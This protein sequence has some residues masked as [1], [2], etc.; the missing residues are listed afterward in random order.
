MTKEIVAEEKVEEVK[1]YDSVNALWCA[2][3][4]RGMSGLVLAEGL[5]QGDDCPICRQKLA[6]HE[7]SQEQ[8]GVLKTA[9]QARKDQEEL[10]EIRRRERDL[11]SI[12][13]IKDPGEMIGEEK[14]AREKELLALKGEIDELKSLLKAQAKNTKSTN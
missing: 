4:Q 1:K 11:R 3:C 8:V 2:K 7:I 5:K 9:A 13:H 14:R 10:A 6:V 12:R